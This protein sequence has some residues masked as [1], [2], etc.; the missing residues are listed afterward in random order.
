ML[1][2]LSK[3][4]DYTLTPAPSSDTNRNDLLYNYIK[5]TELFDENKIGD[6]RYLTIKEE[7][8]EIIDFIGIT[9]LEFDN[10]MNY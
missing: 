5:N 3:V 2:K 6:K 4:T 9:E 8:K 1:E 7:A 10:I